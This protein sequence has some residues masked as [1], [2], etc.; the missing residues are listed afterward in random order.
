MD[1]CSFPQL[2]AAYHVFHRL[3]VPRH[4]PYALSSL[5][6]LHFHELSFI[7]TKKVSIVKFMFNMLFYGLIVFYNEYSSLP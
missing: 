4:S 5:T 6:Y 2:I 3:L 7:F 1:M